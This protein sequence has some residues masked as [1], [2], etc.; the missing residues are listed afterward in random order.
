MATKGKVQVD[1]MNAMG[2]DAMSLGSGDFII[3]LDNL[4]DRMDMAQFSILSAN[5]VLSDTGALVAEPYATFE[6]TAKHR[7]AV[8]GLTEPDVVGF[9]QMT[10]G[11][12]VRVL[13]GVETVRHY[14]DEVGGTADIII[15]LSHMGLEH[16]EMLAKQIPQVDVIIG[17]KTQMNLNPPR[18]LEPTR[19]VIAQVG[20]LG[21]YLGVLSL[22]FDAE[23]DI[24]SVG[25]GPVALGLEIPDDPIMTHLLERYAE[26]VPT[27]RPVAQ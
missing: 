2:Y 11:P 9:L 18:W 8:I 23:G 14:L 6:L 25:G 24:V 12:A 5:V 7:A 1:A 4:R 17:G 26:F 21:Q 16:D 19:T 22:G 20:G 13:D 3:G 10:G 15:V 27:T